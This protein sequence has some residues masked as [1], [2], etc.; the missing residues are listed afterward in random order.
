LTTLFDVLEARQAGSV[1]YQPGTLE[2]E[3]G[4][5]LVWDV[6]AKIDPS[7]PNLANADNGP[8][9][10][11][12]MGTA[13]PIAALRVGPVLSFANLLRIEAVFQHVVSNTTKYSK[14]VWMSL[15]PEE[16]A[17]MLEHYT[18][19]VPTGGLADASQEVPLL[20]CI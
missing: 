1:S 7:G 14:A 9:N 4:G 10:A 13:L 17:I 6:V 20:N 18:I 11:E 15:T 16:R 12:R 3:L 5:P 19:G 2:S 8:Q